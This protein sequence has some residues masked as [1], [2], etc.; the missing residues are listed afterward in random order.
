MTI[1]CLGWGSLIW[2]RENLPVVEP[3]HQDGPNLPLE[4]ARQSDNGRITLVIAAGAQVCTVL[5]ARLEVDTLEGAKSALSMREGPGVN[6][7]RVAY[8]S[9][10]DASPCAEADAVGAWALAKRDI[11]A[12]VWTALGP[13]FRGEA[14]RVPDEKEVVAYLSELK[15]RVRDDAEKYIRC[16]PVQIRTKHRKAI[17]TALGWMPVSPDPSCSET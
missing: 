7:T 3:W 13:R 1:V 15:G 8:W 6:L 16:A 12:V 5:W 17:E 11:E 10:T 14:G 4:F 2:R 9:R